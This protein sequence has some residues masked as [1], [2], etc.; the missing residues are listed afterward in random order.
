VAAFAVD[1]RLET[2][3][4]LQEILVDAIHLALQGK[5]AH[6][7]LCGPMF[8]SLHRQLDQL[9]EAAR[10]YAD[11]LAERCLAIGVAAD[12]RVSTVARATHLRSFL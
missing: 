9:V 11:Q 8:R 10:D 7:N 6:W 3:G 1:P 12:G 5:Q 4:I 2:A